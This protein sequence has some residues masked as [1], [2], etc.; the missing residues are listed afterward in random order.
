[1]LAR[2]GNVLGWTGNIFAVLALV[3]TSLLVIGMLKDPGYFGREPG[4]V[5]GT[6]IGGCV[7]AAVIYAIGRALRY[8][9]AGPSGS[10][11]P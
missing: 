7:F 3:G 4:V 8:V 2:L 1:M 6:G 9:F 5:Y 10:T 11:S